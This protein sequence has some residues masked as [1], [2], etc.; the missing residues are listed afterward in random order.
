MYKALNAYFPVT[1]ASEVQFLV[2]LVMVELVPIM[3]TFNKA[4]VS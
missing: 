1:L 2:S 4:R 3:G